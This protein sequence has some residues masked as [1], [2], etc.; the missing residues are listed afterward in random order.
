MKRKEILKKYAKGNKDAKLK[1][2]SLGMGVQSTALY[3]MSSMGYKIPRADV[4]IFSDTGGE[5]KETMELYNWLLEWREKNNG[6]KIIINRDQNLLEDLLKSEKNN[7]RVS[8]IPTFS[9]GGGMIL[10]QCTYDYKIAPVLKSVRKFLK[11]KPL[12][13]WKDHV[14]AFDRF[15]L[16]K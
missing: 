2:I 14:D 3:L 5:Y 11:I 12:D 6:I 9:D 8:S 4:A 16:S 10:R 1:V 13:N 7:T 15:I